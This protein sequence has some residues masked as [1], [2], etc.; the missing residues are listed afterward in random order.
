MF[1]FGAADT[2]SDLRRVLMKESAAREG[3]ALKW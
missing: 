1:I 2:K 3:F